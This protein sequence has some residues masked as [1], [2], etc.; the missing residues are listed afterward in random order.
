M[1]AGQA[2]GDVVDEENG[3]L[4][5]AEAAAQL[6]RFG[7][8]ELARPPRRPWWRLLVSQLTHFFALL[9]WGA[10]ALALLAGM[11]TLAVAIAVIVLLNGVF[12]YA[13]EHRADRAA[14]KLGSLMPASTRI[15]RDG[16]M[17]EVS[18]AQVVPGDVVLLEAGDRV[19]ADGTLLRSEE[20][21][22][23]ESMLTG[24]SVP[25]HKPV[26]TEI[27]AAT[28]LVQGSG[29]ALVTATGARTEV[30]SV[31]GLISSARRPPSPLDRELD[32]L[33]RI[34]AAVALTVG[35]VLGVIS[36]LLGGTATG[37]LLFAVGVSVALVPEGL[38]P[39][40]TLSLAR[41][42]QRMAESK[43]LVRHLEA[44][45]TLG[46]TTFI[47][48]DKTGTLTRNEMTVVEIWTPAGRVVPQGVGYEPTGSVS[49]EQAAVRTA[50]EA[51]GA[52]RACVTGRA[53][54]EDGAWHPAGD[55]MEV[56]IDVVAARLDTDRTDP[57]IRVPFVTERRFS[58][59]VVGG[60]G[61]FLGAPERI[62]PGCGPPGEAAA[63]VLTAYA[64]EGRRVVAVARS[65]TRREPSTSAELADLLEGPMELLALL[66]IEDPPRDGVREALESCRTAGIRVAM[67]TGDNART[68]AA[69][70]TEVGLLRPGGVVVEGAGLPAED[71]ALADLLDDARGAVVARV[72][73]A[74]KL[75][76]ANALRLHGHVVAMTGDGV[77][78]AAALRGADVGVAMGLGGSDVARDAA[79]LVLLD[80]HFATIVKAIELGRATYANIRRF[81]TFH[82]TDNVAELAPFAVW[83]LSGGSIPPAL[84]VLQILA[85]DI[86]TDML[87][88]LALGAEPPSRR[89]MDGPRPRERVA[90]GSV[91]H[92][93][94]LVLGPVEAVAAVAAFVWVL[95]G[96]G[97]EP[98]ATPGATLLTQASGTAFAVIAISQVANAFACRSESRP[99]W[100]VDPRRNPLVLAAVAVEIVLLAAF[101][102]LP[103]LS[104]MLG[105]SWPSAEGWWW[106]LGAGSALLLVDRVHKAWRSIRR[107]STTA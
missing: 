25:V 30:A 63:P 75:R 34:I 68:A 13:Q 85:L 72:T 3:G 46:S 64:D 92:R 69:I 67:M 99:A 60:R 97:W 29:R 73:P 20:V 84:G 101:L 95:T 35:V 28:F 81:L 55:P 16:R 62:L 39:T 37:A 9:L 61:Y 22:A 41:G 54:L 38:L 76:I 59:A 21:A 17:Q 107:R 1:T 4:S 32:R 91:L 33:V 47:C 8:N 71:A 96:G 31:A 48:T 15:L 102:G 70:A 50:A 43:A 105:G 6:D 53:V 2:E 49:G 90:S 19:P 82:L 66:A 5:S 42:A 65:G 79:D 44:V 77:N 45:E 56:A 12:A 57:R 88:A 24:E 103:W 52:A 94:F 7:P 40:V 93:A 87:P 14:Q 80:D 51:A 86:G 36:L 100:R 89:T 58:A 26:G 11:P 74:D 104:E 23:D 27:R 18:A 98:G 106:A 10:A 83:A 78:D